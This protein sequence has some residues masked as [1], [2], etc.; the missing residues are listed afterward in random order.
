[1][2]SRIITY[3]DARPTRSGG[4]SRESIESL[5]PIF[6][7]QKH[8]ILDPVIL[9]PIEG[10]LL[11]FEGNHRLTLSA[12]YGVGV[13]AEIYHPG[14]YIDYLD[15]GC[16]VSFLVVETLRRQRG[17]SIE[18]G[19]VTFEDLLKQSQNLL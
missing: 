16:V 15:G 18:V 13:N 5:K 8:E 4:L 9:I 7:S 14:E 1:M 2:E 6:E 10:E 17:R 11:P 19:I 12:R 3:K